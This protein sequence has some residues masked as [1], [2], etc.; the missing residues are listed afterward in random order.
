[1]PQSV[2]LHLMRYLYAEATKFGR[3]SA[4]DL[5]RL[6]S[7]ALRMEVPRLAMLCERQIQVRLSTDNVMAL[8]R[9]SMHHGAD[10]APVME[11]CKH[12]FLGNYNACT[13]MRECEVLDPRLLVELMRHHNSRVAAANAIAQ[14]GLLADAR[15]SDGAA[16]SVGVAA[17]A[18]GPVSAQAVPPGSPPRQSRQTR[19]EES[20]STRNNHRLQNTKSGKFVLPPGTLAQDLKS[21]LDEQFEPDFEVVVQDEVIPVHKLVLVARSRYFASCILTSGM[22]E[23]QAGRLVIPPSSAMTAE[24]FRVFLRFLYAGDD[25]LSILA[26]P[27][28]MYLT[29]ASSFYSLSNL[30]L[31]HFCEL[32]VNQAFCEA[33]VLQL[34]EAASRL[35]ACFV[36]GAQAVRT[37]ALDF[38]IQ[39]FQTVCRQPAL[40]QLE[41]SLLVEVIRGVADKLPD[42]VACAASVVVPQSLG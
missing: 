36:D 7:A 9:A 39:H 2:L 22:V 35:A 37:R 23:S 29:D 26:P 15:Q 5:Y 14:A 20:Q 34:F 12:F 1:M 16:A 17:A 4:E 18:G 10:G 13:E 19:P 33:H 32:C 41:K 3:L 28:A 40:E 30:R 27:T 11:A 31:R 21:L 8:L 6:Y 25:I 24:A 42:V 38:I